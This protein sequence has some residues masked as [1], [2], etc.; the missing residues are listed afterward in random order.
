M[1]KSA[2]LTI[3]LSFCYTIVLF[4]QPLI[5]SGYLITNEGDSLLGDFQIQRITDL[6]E[7]VLFS[8]NGT[9][10]FD[11]YLVESIQAFG[12]DAGKTRYERLR[13]PVLDDL[14]VAVP[15]AYED[16]LVRL[17]EVGPLRLYELRGQKEDRFFIVSESGL[18]TFDKQ[19]RE[20]NNYEIIGDV[21][22]I[23]TGD[24]KVDEQIRVDR[25]NVT[26]MNE[27]LTANDY[28][29]QN[30]T[31]Y[32]IEE[33]RKG[34]VFA[35]T[36]DCESMR[37][38]QRTEFSRSMLFSRVRDYNA[39][40]DPAASASF[41]GQAHWQIA[42]LGWWNT[43]KVASGSGVDFPLQVGGMLEVQRNDLMP[44][45]ALSYSFGHFKSPVIEEFG[46][47]QS[48]TQS[49]Y[50]YK[51]QSSLNY[52]QLTLAYKFYP[53]RSVRP[54]IYGGLGF[55][56]RETSL[57]TNENTNGAPSKIVEVKQNRPVVGVGLDAYLFQHVQL[58]FYAEWTRVY[59][60]GFAA[61]VYF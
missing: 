9:E 15:G 18:H 33:H 30:D 22:V 57:W 28:R 60:I 44:E 23:R 27:Y 6:H 55:Y 2:L 25:L 32:R 24:G 19:L 51:E 45:L 50:R 46:V 39:C 49:F 53:G 31:L 16:R 12:M 52:H 43:N 61:G 14:G 38:S 8:E 34:L 7:G 48:V 13:V 26:A 21:A 3:L 42:L 4:S 17:V 20:V 41:P 40:M 29:Y 56:A 59:A 58:R 54:I 10:D 36:G 47:S 5:Y 11:K 37:F 35:L 1:K